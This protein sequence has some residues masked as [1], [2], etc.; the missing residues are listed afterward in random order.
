MSEKNTDDSGSGA[1]TLPK[2]ILQLLH[3]VL[4]AVIMLVG[5]VEFS[6]EPSLFDVF[7]TKHEKR[8]LL[9]EEVFARYGVRIYNL[10]QMCIYLVHSSRLMVLLV[11]VIK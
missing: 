1:K 7:G 6:V 2:L 10:Q 5:I 8:S 3:L 4:S 9:L 11:S